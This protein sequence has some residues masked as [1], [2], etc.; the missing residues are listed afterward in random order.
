MKQLALATAMFCTTLM[1]MGCATTQAPEPPT[2]QQVVDS[3]IA[4]YAEE[5]TLQLRRLSEN[6]GAS[7]TSNP[8]GVSQDARV[9]SSTPSG[10]TI[11]GKMG[12]IAVSPTEQG[13]SAPP[14]AA[15]RTAPIP[16]ALAVPQGLEKPLTL[17]WT[18]DLES[19][20]FIIGKETGWKVI[21][22][23][24]LRVSPVVIAI[25]AQNKPAFEVLR[26]VGAIAG[27]AADVVISVNSRTL[28]VAYPKR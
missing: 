12:S 18:G 16:D 3:M 25:N 28:G 26:D 27:T 13:Y 15:A 24:G 21:E 6:T 9:A 22:P 8:G 14:A 20:I 19:L 23:T 7:R 10:S 1:M 17:A 5:A 4:K 2:K 11:A